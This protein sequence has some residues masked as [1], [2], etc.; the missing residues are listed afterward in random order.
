MGGGMDHQACAAAGAHQ[1]AD[2]RLR[3]SR[4]VDLCVALGAADP[5]DAVQVC[6]AYLESQA[7]DAPEYSHAFGRERDD[8][9]FWADCATPGQLEAYL[10]AILRVI[11][12]TAFAERPRKRLFASLWDSFPE[13]DRRA[14]VARVDPKGQFRGRAA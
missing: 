1:M 9:A 4:A 8:A 14:F 13:G 2:M 11:G 6:A 7:A 3:G 12:R 5:R 10:A